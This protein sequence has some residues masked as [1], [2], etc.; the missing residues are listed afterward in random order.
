MFTFDLTGCSRGYNIGEYAIYQNI[1]SQVAEQR[2]SQLRKLK[3]MLSYMD[4]SNF[5]QFLATFTWFHN[6]L[7][8]VNLSAEHQL[9][10]RINFCQLSYIFKRI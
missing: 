4:S 5:R 6:C 10:Y 1:N 7:K 3:S 2:H 9:M 8:I